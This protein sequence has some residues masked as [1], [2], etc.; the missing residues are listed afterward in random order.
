MLLIFLVGVQANIKTVKICRTYATTSLTTTQM[1]NGYF[2][3][4]A[5]GNS[6]AMEYEVQLNDL[7]LMLAFSLLI[8][9]KFLIHMI[10]FSAEKKKKKK[11]KVLNLSFS[12]RIS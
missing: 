10:C 7:F 11:F 4:Q 6:H 5:M 1:L 9:L 8:I 12:Q 2:L 3:Q